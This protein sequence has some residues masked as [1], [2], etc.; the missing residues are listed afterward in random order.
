VKLL[1]PAQLI[2]KGGLANVRLLVVLVSPKE[3]KVGKRLQKEEKQ[4]KQTDKWEHKVRKKDR[5]CPE[6][7]HIG[8]K[9]VW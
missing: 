4:N 1:H 5:K 3:M 2:R 7:I 9:E 8:T 6:N